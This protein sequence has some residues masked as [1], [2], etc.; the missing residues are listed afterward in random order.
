MLQNSHPWARFYFKNLNSHRRGGYQQ[1]DG[2]KTL[3]ISTK[4]AIHHLME[5]LQLNTK[6]EIDQMIGLFQL[7]TKVAIHKIVERSLNTNVPHYTIGT[8]FGVLDTAISNFLIS[9]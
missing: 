7:N 1:L 4:V 5:W 2:T 6:V 8:L 9:P 3:I